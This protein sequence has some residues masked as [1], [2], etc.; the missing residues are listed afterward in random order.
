[1]KKVVLTLFLASC[2]TAHAWENEYG[3][4]SY[5]IDTGNNY[6]WSNNTDGSTDV[7]GTNYSTGSMWSTHIEN[8]G[9]MR[10]FDGSGNTWSYD[11]DTGMYMNYGTGTICTGKGY[12]R[13]CN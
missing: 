10:G 3:G 11:Q 9:D 4:S 2:V 13:I 6:N 5:D 1:M 12:A 8:D 7:R